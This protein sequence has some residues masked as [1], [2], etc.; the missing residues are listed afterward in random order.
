M[1]R[2]N[3]FFLAPKS[4]GLY[5][6]STLVRGAGSVDPGQEEDRDSELIENGITEVAVLE[7]SPLQGHRMRGLVFWNISPSVS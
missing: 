2:E 5:P 1:T 6:N 4:H 3:K 7:N